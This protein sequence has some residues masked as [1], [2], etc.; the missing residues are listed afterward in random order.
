MQ[1][2]VGVWKSC[3]AETTLSCLVEELMLFSS[4]LQASKHMIFVPIKLYVL[5]PKDQTNSDTW[6]A[7]SSL[8]LKSLI[9]SLGWGKENENNTIKGINIKIMFTFFHFH[10]P[11]LVGERILE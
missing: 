5:K 4:P 8:V 7:C 6:I 9:Y 2:S 10:V 11:S 1:Q 3:D